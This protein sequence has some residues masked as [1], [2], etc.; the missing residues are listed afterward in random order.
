M[1]G[2][3]T[4]VNDIISDIRGLLT[5]IKPLVSKKTEMGSQ[6]ATAQAN[7]LRRLDAI[8]AE[9]MRIK[10]HLNEWTYGPSET[11]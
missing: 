11:K 5:E 8:C 4:M 3:L 1:D 6:A 10:Q 2:E 9:L 7:A